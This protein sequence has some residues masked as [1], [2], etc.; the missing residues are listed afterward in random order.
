VAFRR[1]IALDPGFVFGHYNLGHTLFL[2]GR[3]GEALAAYED[4]QRRD[5]QRNRRQ[6]CRLA[7][8]RFANGDAAGAE[9]DLWRA[10][11]DAPPDEREDLL[12]ETY[13]IAQALLT[14][15]PALEPQ[16]PFLDRLGAEIAKSE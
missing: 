6:A 16:R 5:P 10:L 3:Y 4:G 2:A 9:R 15:H 7:V 12:L 1:V 13:E 11:A 8:M 14:R